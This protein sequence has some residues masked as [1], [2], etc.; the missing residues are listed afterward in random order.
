LEQQL[1]WLCQGDI[2]RAIPVLVPRV[3]ADATVVAVAVE[4][5]PAVL[6]THGCAM[7]K[8]NRAGLPRVER[9]NF[10][11]L[12]SLDATDSNRRALL[13]RKTV[14]PYEALYV[15]P[16]GEF[17]ESYC[18]L[19]EMYPLPAAYFRP[20][21]RSFEGH[22]SAGSDEQNYLVPT[23]NDTRIGRID[24]S[25]LQLLHDKLNAHWTRRLP[26]EGADQVRRDG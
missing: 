24:D 4:L 8:Q 11:P 15:G 19:S 14:E 13:K 10:L 12:L 7:D 2:F 1:P 23:V 3:L 22:P 21:I 9:L 25:V 6:V 16:V 17:G 18:V 20:S 5:G 26:D